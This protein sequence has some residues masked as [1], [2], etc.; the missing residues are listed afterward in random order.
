MENKRPVIPSIRNKYGIMHRHGPAMEITTMIGCPLKCTFC[1]QDGLRKAYGK[2]EMKKSKYLKLE[3]LDVMLDKIPINTRVDFSGMAEPWS[4]PDCTDMLKMT[5]EKG[6]TVAIFSTLYGL[7]IEEVDTVVGLLERFNDQIDTV[8]LHLPDANGN[9]RGWKYSEE[10]EEV[11]RRVGKAKVK[12]GVGA[13]TM[14]GSGNV[15]EQVKDFARVTFGYEMHTRADSLDVEQINGQHVAMTPKHTSSLTCRSTP[16]FDRNVMNPNGD[17][18]LCCMD[19]NLKHII[20]NLLDQTYLEIMNGDKLKEIVKMN[21]TP[22]F[23][24]CSICKSCE[25]VTYI[26][27]V[28]PPVFEGTQVVSLY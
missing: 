8:C 3:D 17:I 25:N 6:F 10:W 19:Y 21:E 9:M 11:F 13:M 4:N 1:P 27:T 28:P 18:V 12:C 15:H 23:N 20:G 22:G 16:F 2:E 5:L 24:K 7:K 26:N 14:D